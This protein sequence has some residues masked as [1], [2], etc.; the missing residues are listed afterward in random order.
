MWPG[1]TGGALAVPE[2]TLFVVVGCLTV[3]A[4]GPCEIPRETGCADDRDR[5]TRACMHTDF[6]AKNITGHK[7]Y[8]SAAL[9]A[10][11]RRSWAH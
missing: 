2:S 5:L 8:N 9:I 10:G 6:F 4:K 11:L 1:G 7:Y 3:I